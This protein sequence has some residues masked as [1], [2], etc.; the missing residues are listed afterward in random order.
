VKSRSRGE[1]AINECFEFC[2]DDIDL[3]LREAEALV[4]MTAAVSM[5]AAGRAILV[6]RVEVGMITQRRKAENRMG[7]AK[8][9]HDRRADRRGHVRKT[10]IIGDNKV[11]KSDCRGGAPDVTFRNDAYRGFIKS[12]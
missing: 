10:R 5:Q 6:N 2:Y 4:A 12:L 8:Q 3:H 1:S 9:G 7:R 11:R